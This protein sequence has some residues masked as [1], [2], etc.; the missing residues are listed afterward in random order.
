MQIH[1]DPSCAQDAGFMKAIVEA[2]REAGGLVAPEP[3]TKPFSVAEAAEETGISESQVR[4]EVGAGR[5]KR[6]EGVGRVLI[7]V[8]SVRAFQRGAI[9]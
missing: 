1:L 7:T 4:R 8:D 3:R 9:N 2:M 6:I 5:L